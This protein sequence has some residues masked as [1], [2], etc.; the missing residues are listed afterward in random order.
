MQA[1][2]MT[3]RVIA[4]LLGV[5]QPTVSDWVRR[6][7]LQE[8]IAAKIR[9]ELVCCDIYQRMEDAYDP[10]DDTAWKT[11]R[12]GMDYHDICFFGEWSARIAE[13]VK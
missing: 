4:Q 8:K 2:G 12:H 7:S 1:Q 10:E 5:S 13:A 6:V 11:L 3:Q 9:A